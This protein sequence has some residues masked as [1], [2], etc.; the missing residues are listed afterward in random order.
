MVGF[1][2][3]S[4]YDS[5]GVMVSNSCPG[6]HGPERPIW[7]EAVVGF[8]FRY[9]LP[10]LDNDEKAIR[11]RSR[12]SW[13]AREQASLLRC[14][15]GDLLLGDFGRAEAIRDHDQTIRR[16][17]TSMVESGNIAFAEEYA[18]NHP[19]P[20]TDLYSFL[21]RWWREL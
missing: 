8:H 6:G 3:D 17:R 9:E 19:I 15:A 7:L 14:Y 2:Y 4:R 12:L 1:E 21:P 18:R 20:Y 10:L 13:M 11:G 16:R 5:I